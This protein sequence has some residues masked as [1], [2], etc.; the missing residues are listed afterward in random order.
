[1]IS[2]AASAGLAGLNAATRRLETSAHNVANLNTQDF[3]PLEVRQAVDA[4]ERP[5]VVVERSK[6][7]RPV[8][9]AGEIIEQIRARVGAQASLR[10]I[11]ADLELKGML[12]DL[13][14]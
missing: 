8:E 13:E 3:R 4:S 1:M 5:Q 7:A 9:L 14:A 10:V 12:V 6:D 11:E 2:D